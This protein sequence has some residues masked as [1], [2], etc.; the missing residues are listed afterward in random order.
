M[1]RPKSTKSTTQT[2]AKKAVSTKVAKESTKTPAKKSV[3]EKTRKVRTPKIK[4][5]SEE[6][7][8]K[9]KATKPRKTKI[10]KVKEEKSAE[11]KVKISA[12][13]V[14][15]KLDKNIE[16]HALNDEVTEKVRELIHLSREQ[17]FLTYK[18]ID[19]S[20]PEIANQPEELQ[21]VISIFNN[22]SLISGP[23]RPE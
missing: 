14:A 13:D 3:A 8:D 21:N 17:G 15:K 2:S 5:P 6:I 4:E 12:K 20:L 18:D 16:P 11:D 19:Q 22:F 23:C 7:V 10:A 1:P 9:V